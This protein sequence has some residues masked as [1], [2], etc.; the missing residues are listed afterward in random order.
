MCQKSM[1]LAHWHFGH[2]FGGWL[3]IYPFQQVFVPHCLAIFVIININVLLSVECKTYRMNHPSG[4]RDKSEKFESKI[5]FEHLTD[6]RHLS[7]TR[8][9]GFHAIQF[10]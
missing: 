7:H 4:S 2:M 10:N 5:V 3:T 8:I 1:S 6:F 9:D